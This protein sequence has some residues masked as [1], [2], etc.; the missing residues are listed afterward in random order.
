[1]IEYIRLALRGII[2]HKLRSFLTMLGV[3]IGIASIIGIVSIVQGTNAK[4]EKSL[5]GS[6][7]NVT[8]IALTDNGTS[9]Y[10]FEYN[11]VPFGLSVVSDEAIEKVKTIYGV[12][13]A[14][15]Y[16]HR[17]LY[18]AG[19]Y[20]QNTGLSNGNLLGVSKDFFSTI[21]YEIADG[22]AFTDDEIR[23]GKKVAVIDNGARNTLFEGENP[24]GKIIEI[25]EEPFTVIGVAKNANEEAVEYNSL[26]EYQ[27]ASYSSNAANVYIPE[28]CWPILF[29]F[30]E[31]QNVAVHVDKTRQM[32][33]VGA[34]ASKIL[35]AYTSAGDVYY[36]SLSAQQE[37]NQLDDLTNSIRLMLIGIASLSLLVGG[38]GVMNIMLVSVTERTSEIGLKK[39]LGA[40]RRAILMQFLTESAVLTSVGGIIGVIV[41]IGLAAIISYA[42]ALEFGV[43]IPW[44]VVAVA[45]SVLIG[46]IFGAMPA[47]RAAK[48]NPI[49]AL[50]RE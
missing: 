15:T 16:R 11:E 28:N 33:F 29:R 19:V 46:V 9:E 31:P 39:A 20:Y 30:D 3:I 38:I 32:S 35:N 6:G 47:Y 37:E 41:G 10:E 18:S 26:E 23:S 1:M 7:N 22:R 14:A 2:T 48:L 49:D 4:L 27:N 40:K 25:K 43:P 17:D 50:R 24:I 13:D 45:F 12:V 21:Q 42:N 5:I 34:R 44:I 8:T 36:A